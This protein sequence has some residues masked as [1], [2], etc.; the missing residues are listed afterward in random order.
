MAGNNIKPIRTSVKDGHAPESDY[1]KYKKQHDSNPRWRQSN[2][3]NLNLHTLGTVSQTFDGASSESSVTHVL[4]MDIDDDDEYVHEHNF[5]VPGNPYMRLSDVSNMK[6]QV[7]E[8]NDLCLI[9]LIWAFTVYRCKTIKEGSKASNV[10]SS[11]IRF[12]RDFF[13]REKMKQLLFFK[14]RLKTFG[15]TSFCNRSVKN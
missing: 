3:V 15:P 9:Q 6:S 1:A 8:Y 5:D 13:L 12:T 10:H 2:V 4:N 7:L 11:E 14:W